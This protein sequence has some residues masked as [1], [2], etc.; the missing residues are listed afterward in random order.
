MRNWSILVLVF[1]GPLYAEP[2]FARIGE[3]EGAVEVQA[4][5][6][7][8]WRPALRNMPVTERFWLRT[9]AG[10]KVEIELDEGSVFRL[11]PDSLAEFSDYTRLSTGQRITLLS[12]DRGLAYFTGEPSDRDAAIL[13]IP[14]AQLSVRRG[15]RL[16]LDVTEDW[17]HASVIEGR[18]RLISP[19]AELDL[20][21]GQMARLSASKRDK[22]FLYG[23]I[24]VL[25]TDRWSESRDKVL[26]GVNARR[27][28]DLPYG[29]ADL[30]AAGTWIESAEY[31]TAWRPP[32]PASGNWTPFRDGK[33][34][35]YEGLGYTWIAAEPWGWL[36]YHHGRWMHGGE[37]LGWLWSPS[38]DPSFRAGE[39]Y[40]M[41][42]PG[43]AGWGPLAP[44]EE[45]RPGAR[46]E[47]GNDVLP[48]LFLNANTTFA[49]FAPEAREIDPAGFGGRP[50][51]PLTGAAFALALPSVTVVANAGVAR[52][53]LRVGSTRVV[54]LVAGMACE[55]P[56]TVTAS[57]P[58][59]VPPAV[60]DVRPPEP[61]PAAPE[62]TVF[63]GVPVPTP[64][65]VPP[66]ETY[67][68]AP[69]YTGVVVLNPPERGHR[70]PK[71][72]KEA[73][74]AAKPPEPA[75]PPVPAPAPAPAVQRVPRN[76]DRM[77]RHTAS[78]VVPAPAQAAAPAAAPESKTSR[79][80]DD[81]PR[82]E[83]NSRKSQ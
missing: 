20:K 2:R 28:P 65:N 73:K 71:R 8:A 12:L 39:V 14:G 74:T 29:M 60:A 5:A 49:K 82:S 64:A 35:W 43:M 66:V 47:A 42:A 67:Y 18:A 23:E 50:K 79:Q 21:E 57:I 56:A 70:E 31:G 69:I 55:T 22:F 3:M 10:A 16:R 61:P 83:R 51:D 27:L 46:R 32:A 81:I 58:E 36:P 33:W 19:A 63:V 78:P 30:D 41:R 77:Q 25:D 38:K 24:P 59:P 6:R 48:R 34:L 11:G 40:W 17:S 26:A 68:V 72:P 9:A 7:D 13:A 4:S 45:W 80:S 76:D 62:P 15:T 37:G 44:G 52:P 1:A 75:T 53:A 54:P